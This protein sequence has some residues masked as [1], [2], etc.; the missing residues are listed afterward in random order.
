EPIDYPRVVRRGDLTAGNPQHALLHRLRRVEELSQL[1]L[2]VL[3]RSAPPPLEC[4]ELAAEEPRAAASTVAVPPAAV[5]EA[6]QRGAVVGRLPRRPRERRRRAGA[7]ERERAAAAPLLPRT[8][9]DRRAAAAA[10]RARRRDRD[11]ARGQARLRRDADAPP[12]GR[13]PRAEALRGDS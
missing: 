13:E 10:Q 7:L 8:V 5:A 2:D 3:G 1:R 9:R 4:P 6:R 12:S 11:R